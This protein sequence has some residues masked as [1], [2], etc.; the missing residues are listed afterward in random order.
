MLRFRLVPFLALAAALLGHPLAAGVDQWT[1]LGPDG[2]AVTALAAPSRVAGLIYAGT[3]TAG[4]FLSRDGGENWQA[5]RTGLPSEER[6]RF[7]TADRSGRLLF[8]ATEAAVYASADGGLTWDRLRLPGRLAGNGEPQTGIIAFAVAPDARTVFVGYRSPGAE[9]RIYRSTD[10]GQSWKRIDTRFGNLVQKL[11]PIAIAPSSPNTVY[12]AIPDEKGR[13]LRSRNN[14]GS[15]S[16][17]GTLADISSQTD[18]QLA[19]DPRDE[20]ILYAAAGNRV[21]RSTSA[22]SNW[23][24]LAPVDATSEDTPHFAAALAIDPTSPTTLYFAFNRYVPGYS[25]W[26]GGGIL[27][28]EGRIFR[29]TNGGASWLQVATSDPVAALGIDGRQSRRL[30]AGVSRI[31]ILRSEARGIGWIKANRGLRAASLCDLTPDPFTRGLL[32][33]SAGVCE[34]TFDVLASNDDL[35]FLKGNADGDWVNLSSGLRNPVRVLEANAIV[36]DPQVEGTLYAATGH[37]LYKST[38][39]G[40]QWESLQEGLQPILEQ[41][42]SIT[43]DPTD[44]QTLYAAGFRLGYPTCGGTCPLQPIYDTAKSTDGGVT[45]SKLLPEPLVGT[46][47]VVDPSNPDV[48]YA[49]DTTGR[50]LKSTDGGATWTLQPVRD[51]GLSV[52]SLATL[53]IDP[54]AP[55]TLYAA[56]YSWVNSTSALIKSTDGGHTWT[57]AEQGFPPG[58]EIRD[59]ALDPENPA[60]LYA[61]TSRGIYL[62]EDTG[63]H[64]TLFSEG[65][66]NRDAVRVRVDPF[67]P[68]TIYAGTKGDGGLFVI[69]RSG[70]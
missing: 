41:I 51:I 3:E 28:Y 38:N 48:L 22:G 27:K 9:Q 33:I 64:W 16:W 23:A 69:T 1:P 70:R 59:L 14:G 12:L 7:V 4:V 32:Y 66:T 39:G 29:T 26:S 25:G 21:A 40:G 30:Y 5:A 37:G 13:I 11:G 44:A 10:G 2:G 68:A 61:A 18:V 19:V 8:A 56:A 15:W 58:T 45:W 46:R 34:Q 53:L 20:H 65:L 50:L 6:I 47:V 35:G 49:P 60:T 31:G 24:R 54:T 63:A 43:V 42:L 55:Q 67:D 57:R 17:V 52:P 62:S 36:P